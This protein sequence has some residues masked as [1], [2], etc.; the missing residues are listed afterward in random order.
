MIE[1]GYCKDCHYKDEKGLCSHEKIKEQDWQDRFIENKD[2]LIYSYNEDGY[3]YVGDYFGCVHFE[4][5]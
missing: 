1:I 4:A 2:C 3:F 5:K